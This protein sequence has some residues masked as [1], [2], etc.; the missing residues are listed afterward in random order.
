MWSYVEYL[1]NNKEKSDLLFKY[2][3]YYQKKLGSNIKV[4]DKL[5]KK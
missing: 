4:M 2:I 3:E 1:R 5:N